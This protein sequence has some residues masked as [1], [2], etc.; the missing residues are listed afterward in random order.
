MRALNN[1]PP[2]FPYLLAVALKITG[3]SEWAMR[4]AF[5]PFDLALACGLY[6]LARR[7]LARPL[8]PVLI[9]LA[10][11]AFVVGSNLLYP[12]KMST[13][14]G[15]IALVG[16]LKGSQENHQ[17]WFWGSA[18]IAAAAMLCKYAAVVFP[19]TVMAYA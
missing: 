16:F 18:L 11:P 7:F 12:D 5:L 13:A 8:L 15:V 19:L 4:L 14:F 10:C 3:G 17:G 1:T 9:V 6:A 2:L